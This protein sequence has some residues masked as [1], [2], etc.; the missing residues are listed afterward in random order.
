[1]RKIV[2][3]TPRLL[4]IVWGAVIAVILFEILLTAYSVWRFH[5][6]STSIVFAMLEIA[7]SGL[8]VGGPSLLAGIPIA[9]L[10]RKFA[11]RKLLAN[12]VGFIV[13]V[14]AGGLL[15]MLV[16]ARGEAV[17]YLPFYFAYDAVAVGIA[18]MLDRRG[19]RGVDGD[20]AKT[21]N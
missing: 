10:L 18:V 1:M 15:L 8:L 6:T 7:V 12:V 17:W 2:W 21:F 19:S 4:N 16:G 13:A 5:I 20:L 11:P 9:V 14:A 3:T